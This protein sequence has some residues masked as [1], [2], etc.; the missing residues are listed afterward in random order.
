RRLVSGTDIDLYAYAT[1]TS[2]HDTAISE[3]MATFIDRLQELDEHL[4]LRLVPLRVGAF[5]PVRVRGLTT[6]HDR[7]L[8]VQDEAIAAWNT[9]LASRFDDELRRRSICDVPLRG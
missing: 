1:F 7:A 6:D 2:P 5:T 9:E 3:K 4:P 8:V